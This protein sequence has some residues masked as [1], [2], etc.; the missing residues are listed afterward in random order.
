MCNICI[1]SADFLKSGQMVVDMAN[2]RLLWPTGGVPLIVEIST[3]TV[4]K[5]NV[6]LDSYLDVF[7]NGPNDPLGRTSKAEHYIDTGDNRPSKQ[8]PYRIPVHLRSVVDEQVKDMLARG[9]IR[10]SNSPWSSPIV[11]APKKDGT[12]RCCV[13]FRR[14]NSVTKKD[15][16]P[17]PRVDDILDQLGGS[18]YFGTLDLASGYWQVL[19]KEEDMEKTAFSV[20]LDHYEFKVMP[21]GLTNAL[22]TFQRMMGKILKGIQCCLV[23]LDDIIF[24]ET[25]ERHQR[26]LEEVLQRIRAAGL[27][28]KRD[29]CQFAR[30]SVKFLGH[31]V[32]ERGT[33]PDSAKVQA[34]RDF[35]TSSCFRDV[36]GFIGMAS[37]YRRFVENFSTIAAPLHELT[38]GG[39]GEFSWTPKQ[40][41]LLTNLKVVF[42]PH[43]FFVY[44]IFPFPSPSTPIPVIWVSGPSYLNRRG[45]TSM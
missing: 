28:I 12:F 34:V 35:P 3:P 6:L 29:K 38:K 20:G 21:F 10:P 45:P 33:E 30:D 41:G 32:S 24:S 26:I 36:R 17:M 27:K 39:Q 37:Y 31:I 13:D 43:Q 25:W 14:V 44:Q 23:F 11:L 2:A 4:S 9:L 42:A 5:L 8:R 16:H 18:H 15:A 22:A 19:L 7:V 1:L 40:I